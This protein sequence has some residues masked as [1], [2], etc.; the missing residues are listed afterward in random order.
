M[1]ETLRFVQSAIPRRDLTEGMRLMHFRISGGTVL[2]YNGEIAISAPVSLN[3]ECCP[4]ATEFTKAIQTC[5]ETIQMTMMPNGKLLVKSGPFSAYVS[6]LVEPYPTIAPEGTVVAID[7]A[8]LLDAVK[9][10][11]PFIAE[12]ASR[13]FARGILLRGASAL[14]TNNVVL[15]E[16]WLG[17][18]MPEVNIPH[19]AIKVL[20][21]I[22]LAPLHVQISASS[23]TFHYGPGYWLRC[24]LLTTEWPDLSRIFD[25]PSNPQPIDPGLFPAVED[26]LPF[27]DELEHCFMLDGKRV[28]TTVGDGQ[29]A[30]VEVACGA[31]RACYNARQLAKLKGIAERADFDAY[32]A[33]ALFFGRETRGAI[34]GINVEG[35]TTR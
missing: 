23:I 21:K 34:I 14:A 18:T 33:P 28:S 9:A 19:E 13:P 29:G 26:I 12:D 35:F 5:R 24:Q 7:G 4:K 3:L 10:L 1:H 31:Q 2:G 25:R 22:D 15:V 20:L 11:E 6:C 30:S 32:P 8:R 17:V 27:V 16:K